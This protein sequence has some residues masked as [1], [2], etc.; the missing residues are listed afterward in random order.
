[1]LRR[2]EATQPFVWKHLCRSWF[3]RR[4]RKINVQTRIITTVAGN[5]QEGFAGDNGLAT[6]AS[7]NR[8]RGLVF[9]SAGNLYIADTYNGRIRRVESA[10]GIIRTVAG[11]GLTLDWSRSGDNGPATAAGLAP[12]DV[13][14]DSKGNLL[15]SDGGDGR[16]RGIRG[17]IP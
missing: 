3:N 10:T 17:P 4:V 2:P 14:F 9:D 11:I 16:V 5:G 1:M 13:V 6:A 15:F 8:P 12:N 7:L